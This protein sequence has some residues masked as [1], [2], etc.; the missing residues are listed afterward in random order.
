MKK[1]LFEV[2]IV[3]IIAIIIYF[4]FRNQVDCK[5]VSPYNN[6][7]QHDIHRELVCNDRK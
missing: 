3:F 4:I 2:I 1:T 5:Y 7:L 6:T